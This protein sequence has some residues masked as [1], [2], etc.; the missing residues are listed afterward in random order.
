MILDF[1]KWKLGMNDGLGGVGCF[2]VSVHVEATNDFSLF[3]FIF[4]FFIFFPTIIQESREGNT[5][6]HE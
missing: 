3:F 2:H 6:T 5:L 4:L 1:I